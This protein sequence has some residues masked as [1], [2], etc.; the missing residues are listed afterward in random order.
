M[1]KLQRAFEV[2]KLEGEVDEVVHEVRRDPVTNK[3]LGFERKTN[4]VPAG[5]MVYFPQ[6]HSMRVGTEEKLRELGFAGRSGFIDMETGEAVEDA[7]N[8]R[9]LKEYVASKTV[10]RV[11]RGAMMEE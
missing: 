11:R 4:K 1:A 6:G 5:F 9:S 8:L 7:G 10:K 2:E 3:F